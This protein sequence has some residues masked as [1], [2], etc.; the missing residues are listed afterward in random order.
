VMLEVD[1][2]PM[3]FRRHLERMIRDEAERLGTTQAL[4]G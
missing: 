1:A 2:G 3:R 4:R